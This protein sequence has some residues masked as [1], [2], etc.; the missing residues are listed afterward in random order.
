MDPRIEK[1]ADVMVN[2]SLELKQGQWVKVQGG[3]ISMP[4]IKA[5]FKKALEAGAYPYYQALVDD[6]EEIF[7]K[8]GSDD[9]L[10]FISDI[11][12]VEVEKLDG[13]R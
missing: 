13:K 2:Y 5:F 11:Q 9:Q 1:L 3:P 4:L 6:L 12:K 10:K 8:N 7:L